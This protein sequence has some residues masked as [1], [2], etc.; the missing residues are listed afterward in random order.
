M[1][2]EKSQQAPA[3]PTKPHNLVVIHPFGRHRRGDL[4][5]DADLVAE[6]KASENAHHCRQV[7]GA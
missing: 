3:A 1:A 4:I 6:V 2:T 7:K 5:S